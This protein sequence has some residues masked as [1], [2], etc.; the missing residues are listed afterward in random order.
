MEHTNVSHIPL[1]SGTLGTAKKA[2][3]V[4]QFFE[5]SHKIRKEIQNQKDCKIFEKEDVTQPSTGPTFQMDSILKSFRQVR[6]SDFTRLCE[7]ETESKSHEDSFLLFS[8]FFGD[9]FEVETNKFHQINFKKHQI[10]LA[11]YSIKSGTQKGIQGND[12]FPLSWKLEICNQSKE[13]IIIDEQIK[14]EKTKEPGKVMIFNLAQQCFCSSLRITFLDSTV[15]Y[16]VYISGI[17]FFGSI[18]DN[19]KILQNLVQQQKDLQIISPMTFG[20]TEV[21]NLGIMQYFNHFSLQ[22]L[23]EIFWIRSFDS[24]ENSLRANLMNWNDQNWESK[25]FW[26]Y[27][28]INFRQQTISN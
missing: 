5:V 15:K 23:S 20:Y 8:N 12:C 1:G 19:Q 13:W 10:I 27:F 25:R 22:N 7:F 16:F 24:K 3:H 21:N 18:V 28:S 6:F 2:N 17:E 14:V 9:Y 11:A 26:S 4:S